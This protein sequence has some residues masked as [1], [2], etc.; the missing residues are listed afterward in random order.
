MSLVCNQCSNVIP[1]DSRYC[2]YCGFG[3][4]ISTDASRSDTESQ[5]IEGQQ[6]YEKFSRELNEE[7]LELK[8]EM[9]EAFQEK[10][11]KWVKV[12][13]VAATS[14]ISIVVAVLA[15]AGFNGFSAS[16]EYQQLVKNS[17]AT[18]KDSEA[19]IEESRASIE[20]ARAEFEISSQTTLEELEAS[21]KKSLSG[22]QTTTNNALAE[23]R[24][25]LDEF[26]DELILAQ[27][28]IDAKMK[29]LGKF[30]T[31]EIKKYERNLSQ[32]LASAGVLQKQAM[33]HLEKIKR[34]E[35]SRIR[36]IVHYRDSARDLYLKNI[37]L[38]ERAL[39]KKGFIIDNDDIANVS[40]DRQEVLYYSKSIHIIDKV[41]EIQ[42]QL[43]DEF[44]IFPMRY[45]SAGSLDSLQVVIKLCPQDGALESKCVIEPVGEN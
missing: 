43:L 34:L 21:S 10:A 25:N 9:L 15:Y 20:N 6:I 36:I 8:F 42:K 29:D 37:N 27:V 28:N 1:A 26:N 2:N 31:D 7:A 18:I 32:T 3:L 39:S 22:L 23:L 35:N 38:M 30:N 14:A 13:F 19:V 33:G 40:A 44:K 5:L 45:Q 17:E 24:I 41:K 16:E 12:Q 4:K 11:T